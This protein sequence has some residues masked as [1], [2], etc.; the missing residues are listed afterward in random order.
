MFYT[1]YKITNKINDKYYVGK[2]QT[3]NLDD[4]YMG[5][6]KLLKKAIA[7]YGIEN[8]TKEILYIFETE[9]EM[10]TKEKELVIV[11]EETYNLCDG[12]KG[13]WG[14]INKNNL[15]ESAHFKK[16][17]PKTIQCSKKAIEKLK[18]LFAN[19]EWSNSRSQKILLTKRKNGYKHKCKKGH[20]HS[21]ETK[22]KMSISKKG[23]KNSQYGTC[24]ITNGKENKKIRKEELDIWIKVGYHKGRM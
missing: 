9:D 16:N 19:T 7:K 18:S 21:Q 24:W 14:Y 10:N 20:K 23:T 17:D 22:T 2:H 12:G 15:N 13:G 4:G 8:F 5:S 11:S 6:G 3:A 1:V